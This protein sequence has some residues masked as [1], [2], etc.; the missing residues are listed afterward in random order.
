MQN[1]LIRINSMEFLENGYI[2]INADFE[3]GNLDL[4]T[5]KS[6]LERLLNGGNMDRLTEDHY[7]KY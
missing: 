4:W 1:K 5:V 7:K 6:E 2:S 3:L